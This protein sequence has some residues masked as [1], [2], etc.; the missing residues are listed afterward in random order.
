[1]KMF[2]LNFINLFSYFLVA[3]PVAVA[4]APLLSTTWFPARQRTTSTAVSLIMNNV[5]LSLSFIVGPLLVPNISEYS[6]VSTEFKYHQIKTDIMRYMYFSFAS[7]ALA[8]LLI[9]VYF[10]SQP[11]SLPSLSA[12]IQRVNY[13]EGT[14]RIIRNLNFWIL[15][16]AYSIPNGVAVGWVSVIDLI[17]SN[18]NISQNTAGWIGFIGAIAA[19]IG[20][21]ILGCLTDILYSVGAL[22]FIVFL[23]LY[24]Q[25][26][27]S[28]A[29]LYV[30]L[31]VTAIGVLANGPLFYSMASEVTFPVGEAVTNGAFT[32]LFKLFSIIFLFVLSVPGVN[33]S[34]MNWCFIASIVVSLPILLLFKEQYHRLNMDLS[35]PQ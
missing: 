15:A 3:G 25:I 19:S 21:L 29:V 2:F 30:G 26:I 22:A 33:T 10:P 1:M 14:K 7:C 9:I 28:I 18:I 32:I 5:G 17:L 24:Y 6:P 4:G 16:L 27:T 34:W 8:F 11:P 20:A 23:F 12:G 13:K 31:I 35:V